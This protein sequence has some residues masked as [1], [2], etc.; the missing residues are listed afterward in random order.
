MQ[1]SSDAQRIVNEIS[2]YAFIFIAVFLVAIIVHYLYQRLN[3]TFDFDKLTRYPT[4]NEWEIDDPIVET[5]VPEPPAPQSAKVLLYF[6]STIFFII[7]AIGIFITKFYIFGLVFYIVCIMVGVKLF[8]MGQEADERHAKNMKLRAEAQMSHTAYEKAR[9]ETANAKREATRQAQLQYFEDRAKLE[10]IEV[11]RRGAIEHQH[12]ISHRELFRPAAFE[13]GVDVTGY[14]EINK[15]GHIN[16][17][18]IEYRGGLDKLEAEKARTEIKD[19]LDAARRLELPEADRIEQLREKMEA[20][21]AK[22]YEIEESDK[23]SDA[24]KQ[25]LIDRYE[26][27][28]GF[29]EAKIDE[30]QTRL[31]S[32]EDGQEVKG[33]SAGEADSRTDYPPE[34]N[35]D[36]V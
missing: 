2:F 34:T 17:Q 27:D 4:P 21:L 14:M 3:P 7:P 31:F 13:K 29:Y 36:E 18:D 1:Y 8:N 11:E 10:T 25:R 6:L 12:D 28:I 16:R 9:I 30:L 32:S 22:R 26:K 35:E 23:Y 5:E 33:H 15:T 19:N 24:H 20:I